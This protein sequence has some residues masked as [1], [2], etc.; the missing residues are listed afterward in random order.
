MSILYVP[1]EKIH[2]GDT[3]A[4]VWELLDED[5]DPYDLGSATVTVTMY[6]QKRGTTDASVTKAIT[7]GAPAGGET[8]FP[9][10]GD[11]SDGKVQ[12]LLD[13][14]DTDHEGEVWKRWIRFQDAG[15]TPN[16]DFTYAEGLVRYLAPCL[17]A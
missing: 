3:H 10:G 2:A 5:G 14:S 1:P 4:R 12:F 15:T 8:A 9:D 11:G 13:T 6:L 17:G 16:T 7:N